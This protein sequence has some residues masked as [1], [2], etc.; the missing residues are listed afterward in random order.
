MIFLGDSGNPD[1]N[2]HW[3]PLRYLYDAMAHDSSWQYMLVRSYDDAKNT[4]KYS[5]I[6]EKCT[7]PPYY[8]PKPKQEALR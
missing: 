6:T 3:V 8:R 2:R 5:G 7:F 1:H 4:W